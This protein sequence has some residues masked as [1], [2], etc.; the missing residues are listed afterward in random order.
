MTAI[1]RVIAAA[2]AEVGYME[3]RTNAQLED[4]T[5]NAGAGNWTKY[6]AYLDCLGVYNGR[7]NGYAWCD[8][9]VDW[10]LIT[11]FGLETAMKMT[12]QPMGKYGAGCTSSANYYQSVGRFH[13]D[14]PQPGDQIFFSNAS[15]GMAHTGLVVEV[16]GGRVYTIEGN[17]SSAA[18]VV[19]NGGMVAEKSYSLNYSRIGGYGRPDWD[20]VEEDDDMT[21]AKFDEM[22][23]NW[24]ARRDMLPAS[25]WGE[26]WEKARAWAEEN[27]II[28]GDG[29]GS[30]M[31]QGF[32]TR[33]A[34]ILMLYREDLRRQGLPG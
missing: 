3:K 16:Q 34:L 2:R 24:L 20:L 26:E 1:E 27:G 10:C 25:N 5:A 22:M 30:M 6:A 18:G 14:G 19:A 8:V 21:Q 31:Y 7:K 4:K 33:Q 9:F 28:R 29:S 12:G 17:T 11:T 23:D 13:K 32:T 15:G